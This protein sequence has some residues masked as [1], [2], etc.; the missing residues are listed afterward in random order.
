MLTEYFVAP[1]EVCDLDALLAPLD[2]I[3]RAGCA[4]PLASERTR[5]YMLGMLAADLTENPP[6]PNL[7][8][9]CRCH[10]V[11]ADEALAI[12]RALSSVLIRI[13]QR[14]GQ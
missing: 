14:V 7:I 12:G 2:A 4:E 9:L 5:A 11:S 6:S 10:G 13:A 3:A 1:P 8:E